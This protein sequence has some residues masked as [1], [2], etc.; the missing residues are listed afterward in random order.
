MVP[1]NIDTLADDELSSGSPPNLF[2]AK[3]SRAKSCQRHSHRPGFSNANGG[4]FYQARRE[5]CQGKNQPNEVP[6][7]V[8][9]L[10]ASVIPPVPQ[11]YLAYGIGHV[12][13][14]SPTTA[15]MKS[16]RHA[17]FSPRAKHPR[18]QATKRVRH[19]YLY[20]VQWF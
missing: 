3:N 20:Y 18:L 7:N 8:S 9:A 12:L 10:H 4:T 2:P 11:T 6:G 14:I 19:A 5:T 1:N 16:Q 15:I 17:L 13:Y